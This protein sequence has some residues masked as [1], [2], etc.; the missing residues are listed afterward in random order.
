M[1]I[2]PHNIRKTAKISIDIHIQQRLRMGIGSWEFN[3]DH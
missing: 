3:Y 1:P 2:S